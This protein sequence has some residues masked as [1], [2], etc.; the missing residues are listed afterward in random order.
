MLS[1]CGKFPAENLFDKLLPRFRNCENMISIAAVE[2]VSYRVTMAL[3][4]AGLFS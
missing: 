1:R 2:E 4:V 3:A